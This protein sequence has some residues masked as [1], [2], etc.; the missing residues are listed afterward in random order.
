MPK[1][2]KGGGEERG[3]QLQGGKPIT[4]GLTLRCHYLL[5]DRPLIGLEP[6]DY[7]RLA[8]P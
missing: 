4:L 7:A 2:S 3:T 5:Q 1:G 8:G 6:A